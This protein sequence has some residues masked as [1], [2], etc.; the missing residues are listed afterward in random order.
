MYK[1]EEIKKK[2]FE[3]L[4]K[5]NIADLEAENELN[6]EIYFNNPDGSIERFTVFFERGLDKGKEAWVIRHIVS[7][8]KLE[9]PVDKKQDSI[10]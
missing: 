7:P 4:S 6:L 3:E 8:D 2:A 10:E 9:S 5:L 1:D